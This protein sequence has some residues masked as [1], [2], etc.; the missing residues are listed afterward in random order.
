MTEDVHEKLAAGIQAVGDAVEQFPPIAYML[1]HLHRYDPIVLSW[2]VKI[3]H[4]RGDD[5]EVGQFRLG[6]AV[7]DV[8]PLCVGID[9]LLFGTSPIRPLW[10]WVRSGQANISKPWHCGICRGCKVDFKDRGK[11]VIREQGRRSG[12]DCLRM[13]GTSDLASPTPLSEWRLRLA[14]GGG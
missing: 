9:W 10:P 6:R 13:E 11:F 12:L 7:E 4:V 2:G 8:R 3:V 14:G 5:L 1:E